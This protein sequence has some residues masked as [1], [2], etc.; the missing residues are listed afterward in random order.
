MRAVTSN[1]LRIAARIGPADG[2][3]GS[4]FGALVKAAGVLEDVHA[5]AS[6]LEGLL[7]FSPGAIT[8]N[9]RAV[10]DEART[11]LTSGTENRI[12]D[13]LRYSYRMSEEDISR[14]VS[15]RDT[16]LFDSLHNGVRSSIGSQTFR[17]LM[18]ED[19]TMALLAGV[20]PVTNEPLKYGPGRGVFYWLGTRA[21]SPLSLKGIKSVVYK[22]AHN[23]AADLIRG[24]RMEERNQADINAPEFAGIPDE[25]P[26]GQTN[27]VD[28]ARAIYADPWVMRTIDGLVQANLT[29]PTQEAVWQAIL[30]DP[31]LLVVDPTGIGVQARALAVA[32]TKIMGVPNQGKSTEVSVG[33]TFRQRVLP[34]MV[35]A[36]ADSDIAKK[37]L[38]Q[39][40][41]LELI[42]EARRRPP[43]THFNFPIPLLDGKR[44]RSPWRALPVDPSMELTPTPVS[45]PDRSRPLDVEGVRYLYEQGIPIGRGYTL[46]P[47]ADAW[48][49]RKGLDPASAGHSRWASAAK[50]A[51]NFW[52]SQKGV[53]YRA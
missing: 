1:L 21:I 25:E 24:T 34:A 53:A 19:V 6:Y 13:T 33:K 47:Q 17:G 39:R 31:D 27:F 3:V 49:R 41:I 32:V 16:G 45:E 14:M 37:L 18:A 11:A 35:D 46:T 9:E 29:T 10:F 30:K 8:R 48:L 2:P 23:R 28:L 22:E 12:V 42:Q 20:S 44:P 15:A 50:V 26:S 40:H 4:L 43:T 52:L 38:R 7:G 5:R 51:F 36:L